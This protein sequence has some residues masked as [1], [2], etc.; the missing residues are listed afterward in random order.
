MFRIVRNA[1]VILKLKK[2]TSSTICSIWNSGYIL[3]S[4]EWIKPTETSMALQ[5]TNQA[6]LASAAGVIVVM[7]LL[8]TSS[9]SSLWSMMNQVQLFFLLFLTRAYIPL[10]V[11]TVI[12]GNAPA[13]NLPQF[14]LV[15]KT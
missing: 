3:K 15:L 7:N 6:I 2:N 5:T 11:K 13:L 1:L 10:D 8:S 9:F 14:F 12:T 4:G